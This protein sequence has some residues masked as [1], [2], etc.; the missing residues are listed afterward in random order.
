MPT[1]R[2]IYRFLV[3]SWL[4]SGDGG[5]VLDTLTSQIDDSVDKMRESLVARFPSYAQDD[6]LT[7]IGRDR[8]IPRGRSETSEHYAQRLIGWRYPRGHRV[9]GSAFALLNQVSEYFGGIAAWTIDWKLNRHV[10]AADGT[11]SFSYGW[12]WAWDTDTAHKARFWIVIEP[13]ASA[14]Q[15]QPGFGDP[16]LWGGAVG[17]P[18]YS[19]GQLGATPNDRAAIAALFTGDRPWKP[20]GTRQQWLIVNLDGSSH[21]PDP[22][23]VNW[24]KVVA[25]VRSASRASGWRFWSLFEGLNT[26]TPTAA[27]A[28]VSLPL[29]DGTAY[30]AVPASAL[31]SITLPDGSSYLP[32]ADNARAA[33]HLVDDGD[34]P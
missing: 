23:W 15:V 12:P 2:S 3:P 32:N 26:Y 24:S 1:L 6:A 25:G 34:Q 19:I 31:A 9:R 27:N 29:P 7:L 28:T 17:T 5:K 11:E 21:T 8:G 14:M 30:V 13:P 33:V 4:S 16:A 22:T 18:G 20:A 10:R